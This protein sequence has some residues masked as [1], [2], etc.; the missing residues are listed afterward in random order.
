MNDGLT[1]SGA[2]AIESSYYY[3]GGNVL[4]PSFPVKAGDYLELFVGIFNIPGGAT[5]EYADLNLRNIS[6][7]VPSVA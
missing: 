7:Y 6:V 3:G 4:L 1:V 2:R 5:L